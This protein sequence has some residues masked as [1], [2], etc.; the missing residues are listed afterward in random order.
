MLNQTGWPWFGDEMEILLNAAGKLEGNSTT[1]TEVIGNET[2]WQM[3]TNLMKSRLGGVGVGGLLEGEPR[4]SE[5]AWDNYQRWIEKGSMRSAA[6]PRKGGK[7]YVIEVLLVLL[8]LLLVLLLL[9]PLTLTLS[10]LQWAIDFELM[11][12]S[13]GNPY[14]PSMPD[15]HM[16]VNIALGDVDTVA[17]GDKRFG[18]RHENW[19]SGDKRNRTHLAQFGSLTMVHSAE[20]DKLSSRPE[21]KTVEIDRWATNSSR[22]PSV[23]FGANTTGSDA[24]N[25]QRNGI[26]NYQSVYF[27]WQL[28]N[29]VKSGCGGEEKKLSDN[30]AAVKKL[31]P[32]ATT[33]VYAGNG[34]NLLT[35]YDRQKVLLAPEYRGFFLSG[36]ADAAAADAAID[37]SRSRGR[38]A[39]G[40]CPTSP[41][42]WDM[43]NASARK[44]WCNTIMGPW[45]ED[46]AVDAI[47]VDEGDSIQC[48]G[49]AGLPTA[50]DRMA[51]SNG[52][53]LAYRC[54]ANKLAAKGKRLVLSLKSGY[55][56]AAPIAVRIGICPVPLEA[57]VQ[58]MGAET[59]WV[60]FHEVRCCRCCRCCCRFRCYRCRSSCC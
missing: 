15:T 12:I 33:C 51:W 55:S 49:H 41:L 40:D 35:F 44:Y 17:L 58:A 23:W 19:F 9:L 45:A 32:S 10:L 6:K 47:F 39:L 25:L 14:H 38:S 42:S 2:Q 16:G 56:G 4:S 53:V 24:P 7:G 21:L 59:K 57:V 3:V 48:R 46:P 50:A 11:Q 13:K 54:I 8:V 37:R 60:R 36:K 29:N 20:F 30:A 1:G 22:F 27:G 34:A 31:N 28:M 43:R 5:Y 52:S 18:I 26:E